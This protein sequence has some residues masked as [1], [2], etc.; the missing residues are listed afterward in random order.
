MDEI[1]FPGIPRILTIFYWIGIV[2]I[3][4]LKIVLVDLPL[5]I[6][7]CAEYLFES[8]EKKKKR[9]DYS[10]GKEIVLK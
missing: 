6:I 10:K 2:P 8:P 1:F 7:K 3:F 5:F 4:I 9:K